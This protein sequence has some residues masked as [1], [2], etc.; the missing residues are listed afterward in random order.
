MITAVEVP[1]FPIPRD[2]F[3]ILQNG[4]DLLFNVTILDWKYIIHSEACP[5]FSCGLF[6]IIVYPFRR[7]T[8]PR[9]RGDRRF[10][11]TCDGNKSTISISSAHYLITQISYEDNSIRLVDPN[12]A[13]GSC[14]LPSQS[15]SPSNISGSG[16]DRYQYGRQFLERIRSKRIVKKVFSLVRGEID[17]ASCI[18]EKNENILMNRLTLGG[19]TPDCA[20]HSRYIS[21]PLV[22]PCSNPCI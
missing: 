14:G 18:G 17:F 8:D 15:L 4:F 9:Q 10:E 2:A 5:P 22:R 16:V 11:L 1:S 21:N 20:A 12:F 7:S 19:I 6:H 13:G 3:R